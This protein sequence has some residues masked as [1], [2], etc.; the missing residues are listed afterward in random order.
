MHVDEPFDHIIDD[1]FTFLERKDSIRFLILD[2][3]EVTQV[4]VLHDH[5]DPSIV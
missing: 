2:G 4:A 5:E 1:F 3:G